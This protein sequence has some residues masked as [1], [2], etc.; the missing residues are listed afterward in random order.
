VSSNLTPS[1]SAKYERLRWRGGSI[2]RPVAP[3]SRDNIFVQCA[4]TIHA[5]IGRLSQTARQS[6]VIG[7]RNKAKP[8][9]LEAAGSDGL[10]IWANEDQSPSPQSGKHFGRITEVV[11]R[12]C[13]DPVMPAKLDAETP[14]TVVVARI[15]AV[16][17]RTFIMT[18]PSIALA[19]GIRPR[20]HNLCPIRTF[21]ATAGS[22]LK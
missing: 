17:A 8:A 22:G 7:T 10:K 18:L 19:T 4:E 21:G 5:F 3:T 11:V 15:R 14:L 20:R 9:A 6:C 1:A 13:D 12:V 2:N 16:S